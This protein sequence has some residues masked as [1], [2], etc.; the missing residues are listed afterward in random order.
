[1]DEQHTSTE[2]TIEPVPKQTT[3]E[4][5]QVVKKRPFL[6]RTRLGLLVAILVLGTGVSSSLATSYFTREYE[7]K[8]STYVVSQASTSDDAGVSIVKAVSKSVVSISSET[9]QQYG[10]RGYQYV[11]ESA[12]T[13]VV[14]TGDGYIL[15]NNHVVENARTVSVMTSDG[16][17]YPA[18]VVTTEPD[19]DLALIKVTDETAE[20]QYAQIGDSDSAAVGQDVY[21]IGNA[22]GRYQ[23]SVTKGIVS[24]LGR[25]ITT[26]GSGLRGNLQEFEDLIQ[27]DAAINSGNSGGPLINSKGEIIGI[28][29]AVDGE[30][31]NI[32]FAI[33]INRAADLIQQARD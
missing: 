27:T 10:S 25:P 28:N 5:A 1:M 12:G 11:S 20:F 15:T 4:S 19:S 22:L 13:G 16:Q 8:G 14:I 7:E 3:P 30:A 17:E 32:G 33:P 9:V 29:T 2:T 31:Q 18:K 6:Q 24:G 21:A 23:N 26:E